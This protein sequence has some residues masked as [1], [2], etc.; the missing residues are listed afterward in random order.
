M[1]KKAIKLA[2][3]TAIAA[4]AFVA[5]APA[6]QADAAV[7]V[8]ALVK[9]AENAAGA[10]K[11]A[12]SVEGTADGQTAP[13]GLYNL[14]KDA[15]KAAQAAV[16]K[17]SGSE[18]VLLSARLQ[19]V[20]LQISRTMAYIDGITAGNKIA[21]DTVALNAAIA[22]KDLDKVE[23]AYH[24]ITREYKKQAALLDRVYGQ[25]TRDVIRNATK[26][27][28]EKAFNSVL[29]DV[30]VKM[31]LDK[32]AEATKAQDWKKAGSY[33]AEA[34]KYLPKVSATFKDQLTK[35]KNDAVAA[36]PLQPVS[37]TRVNDTTVT[38]NFNKVVDAVAVS[39]FSFDNDLAVT[40]VKLSDDKKVATLTTTSQAAN[41]TY[42][43]YYKGVKTNYA[44]VK[45]VAA[46]NSATI[47][48]DTEVYV[49]T[50]ASRVFTASFINADGTPYRGSVK[51]KTENGIVIDAINGNN[52]S[53]TSDTVVVPNAD[54]KITIRV[55]SSSATNGKV[56][57]IREDNKKEVKTGK[58]YFVA[59]DQNSL[60]NKEV[61]VQYV[62]KAA[63]Y[64]VGT[65]NST[66]YYF[67]YDSNDTLYD[68]GTAINQDTF[69]DN[70]AKGNRVLLTY[71]NAGSASSV[72]DF[73]IVFKKTLS[74]IDITTPS[75][76]TTKTNPF[77]VAPNQQFRLNGTGQAGYTVFV[78]RYDSGVGSSS[79][80]KLHGTTTV[81]G[82]GNWTY[83]NINLVKDELA[84]FK[85][86]Q[87]PAGQ[88]YSQEITSDET[89]VWLKGAAFT[90]SVTAKTN[91][92]T[93]GV[94]DVNDS[95]E[96]T[97]S[98]GD[99]IKLGST[100][101][102]KLRDADGTV[103]TY[104]D[105][106]LGTKIEELANNRFKVT[107]GS[108]EDISGG[109]SVMA[110]SFVVTEFN[111]ITNQH[112]LGLGGNITVSGL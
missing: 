39:H 20:E 8:E 46:D 81:D 90:A 13:H 66:N 88:S 89:A 63:K 43:L 34:E 86:I 73:N 95:V 41:K 25:S 71:K 109:N 56:T 69:A 112:G 29:Y 15:N 91:V 31:A 67:S 101:S 103:A 111:G 6:N 30:T 79:K 98:T 59:E 97:V 65:Y 93:L 12:I 37:V 14:T 96:F 48:N 87:L 16:A 82:S 78:Y 26:A 40:A 49:K 5:A 54:G 106:V 60:T 27:P 7:N 19:A 84:G 52:V 42:T 68:H 61:V 85:A 4:S 10:L 92:G 55:T 35:S 72:S 47:D 70:L 21:A 2:T 50:G 75:V 62:D 80:Y 104:T 23:A 44:F 33:M 1:K 51:I 74:D 99:T 24:K 110:G 58:T 83:S 76:D 108:S 53:T 100:L 11:W 3:S 57:F 107:F 45:T 28:A 9:A 64:F 77:R 36:L 32:V 38:V 17:T 102:I 18:K 94:L 105:G 22:S